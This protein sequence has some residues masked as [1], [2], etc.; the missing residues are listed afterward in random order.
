MYHSTFQLNEYTLA[1]LFSRYSNPNKK[2]ILFSLFGLWNHSLFYGQ[3]FDNGL[4]GLWNK[5]I[6]ELGSLI[7]SLIIEVLPLAFFMLRKIKKK[8]KLLLSSLLN[9]HILPFYFDPFYKYLYVYVLSVW[10]SL[11]LYNIM[12]ILYYPQL[13]TPYQWSVIIDWGRINALSFL[14]V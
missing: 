5:P 12:G 2:E 4:K 6:V 1:I 11:T 10:K 7:S 8:R 13:T 14:R 3:I 9:I